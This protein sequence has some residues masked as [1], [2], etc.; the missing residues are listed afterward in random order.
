[1]SEFLPERIS[2]FLRGAKVLIVGATGA[3]GRAMA[4]ELARKQATVV[5]LGR[6]LKAL[7]HLYDELIQAG[8]AAALYPLNLE[9]ASGNDYL[10]L[11]ERLSQ[12]LQT[13][14]AVFITS[15]LLGDLMPI[16]DFSAE[17]W[18]RLLHVNLHA[19]VLLMSALLPLLRESKGLLAVAL[20][21]P[22]TVS[23]AFWGG[24]GAAQAGLR[25]TLQ[26]LADECERSG[27]RVVGTIMPP[28][29]SNLRLKAFPA[30][31]PDALLEPEV[32]ARRWLDQLEQNNQGIARL[33]DH[34]SKVE[35]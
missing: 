21:Q 34:G 17:E 3:L 27:P 8:G 1:M 29:R 7:E 32:V 11:G 18:L 28:F 10:E 2:E 6:R 25:N 26:T 35:H 24:Y 9:G 22:E 13:L 16:E 33:I 4:K 19:P 5:L 15:G 20:N 23:R 31:A 14:D 30:E 12:E